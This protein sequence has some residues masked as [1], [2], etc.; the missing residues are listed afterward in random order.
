M[1][2]Q[3]Y[4]SS[5]YKNFTTQA[6]KTGILPQF[7]LRDSSDW[8]DMIKQRSVYRENKSGD[9]FRGSSSPLYPIRQSNQTRLTYA[10]GRIRCGN[11]NSGPFILTP[12]GA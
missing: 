3:S 10:F 4:N 7:P 2:A 5:T 11:C 1:S 12:L 9:P 6:D 8:V